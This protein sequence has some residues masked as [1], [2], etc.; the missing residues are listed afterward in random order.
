MVVYAPP[1][2]LGPTPEELKLYPGV[3]K[4]VMAN[5]SYEV[6]EIGSLNTYE[7]PLLAISYRF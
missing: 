2:T 1:A 7:E 6:K 5:K 3:E 4:N